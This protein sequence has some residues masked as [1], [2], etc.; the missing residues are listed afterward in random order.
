MPPSQV[1]QRRMVQRAIINIFQPPAER[2]RL[3]K[4]IKAFK[5]N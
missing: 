4:L 2:K 1:K 3:I 5:D